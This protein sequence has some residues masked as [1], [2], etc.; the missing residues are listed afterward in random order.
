MPPRVSQDISHV[1]ETTSSRSESADS[2]RSQDTPGRRQGT[3]SDGTGQLASLANTTLSSSSAVNAASQATTLQTQHSTSTASS[4]LVLDSQANRPPLSPPSSPKALSTS[5]SSR[6]G[7]FAYQ[8]AATGIEPRSPATRRPPASRSSHGI[9]TS[10]GPPPA[11]STQRS[12]P[13]EPTWLQP[14]QTDLIVTRPSASRAQTSNSI[15]SVIRPSQIK[16]DERTNLDPIIAGSKERRTSGAADDKML[17]TKRSTTE[18]DQDQTL[19]TLGSIG[20]TP[21]RRT[22][23]RYGHEEEQLQSS[24]EDLFLNL[25]QT[26]AGI[27]TEPLN[28][29]ER[30]RVSRISSL[31]NLECEP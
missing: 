15:D 12:Y 4:S 22:H 14:P 8:P 20:R 2:V 17:S 19:R 6:T 29:F 31:L 18:D 10:S 5:L 3:H 25:A 27:A 16:T 11:F 30:R 13:A 7:Y 24:H 23:G 1:D 28:R 9:E 21:S 26:D